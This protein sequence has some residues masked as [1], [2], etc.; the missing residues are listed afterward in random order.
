MIYNLVVKPLVKLHFGKRMLLTLYTKVTNMSL[1]IVTK[2]TGI[3]KSSFAFTDI[4]SQTHSGQKTVVY[5][6]RVISMG[7][8]PDMYN[9]G[10]CMRWEC[11]ERFPRRLLQRYPLVSDPGMHHGTL[12]MCRDACRDR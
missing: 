4:Y 1:I 9:Y 12:R 8:L 5:T 6:I 10:L 2:Y 3:Y 11:R 7:L